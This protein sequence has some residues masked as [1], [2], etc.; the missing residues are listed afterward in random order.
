MA[1][2]LARCSISLNCVPMAYPFSVSRQLWLLGC[3]N[4]V[5]AMLSRWLET[6]LDPAAVT[7]IDPFLKAAP[8]GV[9]HLTTLPAGETPPGLLLIGVKP[10]MFETASAGLAGVT[11]PSTTIASVMAGV[12]SATLSSV[13]PDAQAIFRIMPNLPV[14]LGKGVA[15]LHGDTAEA[16]PRADI[17]ALA[18][19]LGLALWVDSE[20]QIDA[21]T[22]VSGSGPAF[23]YRFIDAMASGATNLGFSPEQAQKLALATVEGAAALAARSAE[24]PATLADKVASPGGTTRAGLNVMDQ[25]QAIYTLVERTLSAAATRATELAD[26]ARKARSATD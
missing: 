15:L 8:D 17:D 21:G 1:A 22:A 9:R 12:D 24:T 4:M 23:V 5:G 13:F 26:E 18:T 6:G 20:Q 19:P 10:Q 14:A 3:G 16:A 7:V 11:G 2:R 25:D